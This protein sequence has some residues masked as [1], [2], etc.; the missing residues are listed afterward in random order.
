MAF[1]KKKDDAPAAEGEEAPE[2]EAAAD[3][4]APIELDALGLAGDAEVAP[5]EA[6][7]APEASNSD[8]LLSMF[9]DTRAEVDDLGVLTDLAGETDIDDILEELRTLRA[10]LGITDAFDDDLSAAA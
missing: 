7:A 1:G 9:K 3:L 5:T 4:S 10:A 6:P 8:A 2:T